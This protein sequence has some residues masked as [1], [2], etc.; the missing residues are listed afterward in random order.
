[1]A[2]L[3]LKVDG[4][5]IQRPPNIAMHQ[6]LKFIFSN[7][8]IMQRYPYINDKSYRLV[9]FCHNCYYHYDNSLICTV[10]NTEC[11]L[12]IFR[13]K[14]YIFCSTAFVCKSIV[15]SILRRMFVGHVTNIYTFLYFRLSY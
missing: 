11:G 14:Y 13:M 5:P 4:L 10:Q 12:F 6:F 7:P 2:Y 8:R 9:P 15:D 1:M 3:Q